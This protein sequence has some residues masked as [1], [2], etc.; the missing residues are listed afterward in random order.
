MKKLPEVNRFRADKDGQVYLNGKPLRGVT[1]YEIKRLLDGS[2]QSVLAE[3]TLKIYVSPELGIKTKKKKD[4]PQAEEM[5]NKNELVTSSRTV[6]LYEVTQTRL[7]NS[8]DDQVK[9]V[10]R[11]YDSDGNRV[12]VMPYPDPNKESEI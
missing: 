4:K 1:S 9:I 5:T 10:K 8:P 6:A 2:P 7:G 12:Q 3:L 11:L